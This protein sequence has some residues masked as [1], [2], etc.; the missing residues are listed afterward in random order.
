MPFL[1]FYILHCFL[2]G[3]V[4]HHRGLLGCLYHFSV[5]SSFCCVYALDFATLCAVLC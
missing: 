2:L 4:R 5:P 1:L 3:H